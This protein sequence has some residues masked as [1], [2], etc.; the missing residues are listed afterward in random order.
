MPTLLDW[1]AHLPSHLYTVASR[2]R[3]R[4]RAGVT[5]LQVG[6]PM[7]ILLGAVIVV[8]PAGLAIAGTQLLWARRLLAKVR[9]STSNEVNTPNR[10][11]AAQT[12]FRAYDS[13]KRLT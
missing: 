6:L 7:I 2:E 5:L 10:N 4:A 11:C 8:I 3:R 13:A 12:G 9:S 1:A